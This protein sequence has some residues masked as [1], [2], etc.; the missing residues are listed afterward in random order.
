[1]ICKYTDIDFFKL[2]CSVGLVKR[3]KGVHKTGLKRSYINLTT[4]FDIETTKITIG[5]PV[6]SQYDNIHSF[7]YIWMYQL[8]ENITVIGRTWDEF[9]S[10]QKEIQNAIEQYQKAKR[11]EE[12][13]FLVTYVHNLSYEAQ[14]LMGEY[15]FSMNDVFL[16]DSRK[17]LKLDI[18]NIEM[19]CSYRLFNMSLDKVTKL[20]NCKTRKLSGEK[21]DYDKIRY[22]WTEL[23]NY[24]KQYCIN[25]VISLVEAINI[26]LTKD[27][28]T[29]ETI[30]LTSTG[31][32]RR[33]CKRALTKIRNSWIK[34]LL[35]NYDQFV[36]LRQ[37][38]RGGNTHANRYYSGKI[39]NDV[40]SVD[41]ASC[42][43][44]QQL[45]K[46]FPLYPFRYLTAPVKLERLSMYMRDNY[47]VVFRMRVWDLELK[48]KREPIP[49]LSLSRTESISTESMELKL[50]NG[51][52]LQAGYSEMTMTEIDF[53]IFMK[54]YKFSNIE[55]TKAMV[56]KKG[57]LPQQYREVIISYF[58]KK[59]KLKKANQTEDEAYYYLKSKESLN[60][61]YGMSA[62]NPLMDRTV[63]DEN[64]YRTIDKSKCRKWVDNDGEFPY[65]LNDFLYAFNKKGDKAEEIKSMVES[66]EYMKEL[67]YNAVNEELSKAYFPY[68]WGVY[69]TAYARL[70]LQE[71]I[72]L[73]GSKIVYV[74]T[75]SI[76]TD[77]LVDVTELNTVRKSLAEANNAYAYDSE[78]NIHYM[79]V[80][81]VDGHYDR[82]ITQGAKRYA[83]EVIKN[84]ETHIGVTV[85]GV[86]KKK[87]TVIKD[88]KEVEE[89]WAVTE[90]GK[91]ENFKEGMVWKNAGGTISVYND[92]DNFDYTDEET[93]KSVHIGKNVSICDSTYELTLTK[94]YKQLLSDIECEYDYWIHKHII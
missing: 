40:Y 20:Y 12:K 23:S 58:E 25:D 57:K 44:A 13:P 62:Q 32:V 41:M 74:D 85:S 65:E 34:P 91:L 35:P 31:Y 60:S 21:F 63:Y 24:E 26:K 39:V 29:L 6:C 37:A 7:M 88:G 14:F 22:P 93:G 9:K 81:E 38:F 27:D 64:G 94:D 71:G 54:Q 46:D 48:N 78:N 73:A 87:H 67:C 1:M 42:Y 70:A 36:L 11:L 90:L 17:V 50:D 5:S 28:D 61:V 43:P 15:D 49:Y 18:K 80:F 30:P 92:K 33:D 82:F 76:K 19:R 72:D 3:K 86:T 51:R 59:N 55:I 4:A 45:T 84:G 2:I 8:G 53:K 79:G 52:I 56:S 16:L 75:D 69:T 10:M 89:L 83:Y 66:V 47:A 68:Q 77:G